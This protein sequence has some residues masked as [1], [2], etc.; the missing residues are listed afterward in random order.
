MYQGRQQQ[1]A[2]STE[3]QITKDTRDSPWSDLRLTIP[4]TRSSESIVSFVECTLVE[5]THEDVGAEYVSSNVWGA[6]RT[7]FIAVDDVGETFQ[8]HHY[9]ERLGW[10]EQT[11]SRQALREGLVNLL[12]RSSSLATNRSHDVPVDEPDTFA[13]KARHQLQFETRRR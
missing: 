11:I 9:D 12:S 6:K 10:Y 1:P 2:R 3:T 5:L 7:Q 8:K 4:N 13:V